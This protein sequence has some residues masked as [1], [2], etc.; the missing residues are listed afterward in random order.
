MPFR[1]D[2]ANKVVI[3]SVFAET[4]SQSSQGPKQKVLTACSIPYA[5]G[6]E[7]KKKNLNV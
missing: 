1:F 6:L 5:K 2:S 7:Q 4:L 3:V